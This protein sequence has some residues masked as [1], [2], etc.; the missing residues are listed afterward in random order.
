MSMTNQTVSLVTGASSGIGK[1][2]AKQLLDD[3]NIVYTAAR[4]IDRMDDLEKLGA[5]PIKMDIS[6]EDDV[7]AA[8]EKIKQEHEGVDV[9]VNNAG[10]GSYGAMED[11]TIQ[12]AKYQFEVNL[13]GLARLTQAV[14]PYMREKRAGRIVNITSMGGKIYTP[15]GSWYHATKHALEGWSDCLRLE[16][17][18]FEID[19]IIIEPGIIQSEFGS[20]MLGPLMERS[21]NSVYSQMAKS[22]ESATKK[23]YE[24]GGASHPSLI[25]K[26]ISNALKAKR[27][28]TRYAVGKL[29]KPLIFIRK[30][31]G[32]RIFDRV[33][34]S[35]I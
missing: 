19:V 15:L 35:Q 33:V 16:L 5:I 24:K 22:V 17:K 10:F 2:I 21:G 11:T 12:D 34:M 7:A 26:T 8:V 18:P 4:R 31:F 6:K 1:E 14:L 9:L 20:T 23:T 28:K 32:D 30:W 25:A 29:A 3:G 27:P 13:F